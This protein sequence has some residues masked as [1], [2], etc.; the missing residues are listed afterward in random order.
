MIK[1]TILIIAIHSIAGGLYA[2]Q[3]DSAKTD[4]KTDIKV[5]EE[6][7]KNLQDEVEYR[8]KERKDEIELRAKE[9]E[10]RIEQYKWSAGIILTIVLAVLSFFGYKRI[11]TGIQNVIKKKTIEGLEAEWRKSYEKFSTERTK[12]LENRW[13][14]RLKDIEKKWIDYD[15]SLKKALTKIESQKGG[16]RVSDIPDEELAEFINRL[17]QVKI[18]NE[19]SALDWFIKADIK[20]TKGE[21]GDA[22]NYFNKSLNLAP[23]EKIAYNNRGYCYLGMGELK[24]AIE[25][26]NNAINL[27]AEY[28]D[29]YSNRSRALS[30]LRD[31]D[32]A[33]K[34]INRAI[35]LRPSNPIYISNLTTT[36]ILLNN[37]EEALINIDKAISLSSQID[38]ILTV[39]YYKRAI[40]Q[41]ILGKETKES[42]KALNDLLQKDLNLEWFKLDRFARLTSKI[43]FSEDIR[44]FIQEKT[45]LLK[46][47]MRK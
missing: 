16:L 37:Y 31:F 19:Y 41:K 30:L 26:F 34:D 43:D 18:E 40:I 22:V 17:E 45:E 44:K 20:K 35:E 24:K 36:L 28:A 33:I 8:D 32:N 47:K 21:F 29:A 1:I 27:D 23:N 46:K 4:D 15:Q 14:S 9:L 38:D 13:E 5:L 39:L 3:P 7:V 12:E 25:D 11:D 2:Q 10:K 42:D 6:R